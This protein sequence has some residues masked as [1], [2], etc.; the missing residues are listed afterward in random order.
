MAEEL[1]STR[2][3]Q[4]PRDNPSQGLMQQRGPAALQGRSLTRG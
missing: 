2:L 1:V 3:L 4:L